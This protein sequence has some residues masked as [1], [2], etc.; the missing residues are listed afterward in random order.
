[1]QNNQTPPTAEETKLNTPNAP[2]GNGVQLLQ[3]NFEEINLNQ[4]DYLQIAP[5]MNPNRFRNTKERVENDG[6]GAVQREIN[7]KSNSRNL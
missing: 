1:M 7:P 2:A 6:R 5:L 4:N 3:F